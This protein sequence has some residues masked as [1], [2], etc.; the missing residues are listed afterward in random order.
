MGAPLLAGTQV[1]GILRLAF[2]LRLVLYG[3]RFA[4]PSGNQTPSGRHTSPWDLVFSVWLGAGPVR[5]PLRGPLWEPDNVPMRHTNAILVSRTHR[6]RPHDLLAVTQVPKL[7]CL[8]FGLRLALYG[9]RFAALCR[10]QT[11]SGRHTGPQE[12]VFSV[13]LGAGPVRAP[14]RGPL[15][16]PDT[17]W[18][19]HKSLGS[20]VLRCHGNPL[21]VMVSH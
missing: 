6:S 8:A 7:L 13:W 15:W 11:P 14:L 19:A 18:Q 3:R 1:H 20:C 9:R 5:A 2:G 12:L 17:F 10:N 21:Q 16:E 4:V